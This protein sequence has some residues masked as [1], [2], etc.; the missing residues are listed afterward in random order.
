[1]Y[2]T[3]RDIATLVNG[4]LEGDEHKIV[5]RPCSIENAQTEAVTFLMHNKYE[6]F[7]E[8]A[9]VAVLIINSDYKLGVETNATIIRAHHA[10]EAFGK[11]LAWYEKQNKYIP[12]GVHTSSAISNTAKLGKGVSIGAFSIIGDHSQLGEQCILFEQ[13]YIGRDVTIGNNVIIYPGARIMDG[14]NIG[15]RCIIHPN[16]V[17]GSDGFGYANMPDGSYKKIPHV[18]TVVLEEDVEIG[19]NTTIDRATIG[20][21]VIKKG[22]KLDNLVQIGHN[23]EV[24]EHTVMASQAGIAGSTKIGKH[25]RIG[26]QA[27]F[28]GHIQIADN[29]MIQA[30]SGIAGSI[31]KPDS[32]VFGSPAIDYNNYIKSYMVFKKLPDLYRTIHRLEQE[33]KALKDEATKHS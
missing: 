13:V 14:S 26:G 22:V 4:T 9:D 25:C 12:S 29:T 10:Y 17:I 33:L 31:K 7:L 3:A 1:M 16:A 15:D 27:G 28:S 24:D 23:V 11:Y 19:A 2:L 30:Q 18:G 8:K 20:E 6:S 5:K 32:K 21:T